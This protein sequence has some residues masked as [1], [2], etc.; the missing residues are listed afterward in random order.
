MSPGL[1][2]RARDKEPAIWSIA[3]DASVFDA[4]RLMAEKDVGLLL[5][6]DDPNGLPVGVISE[7]DYARRVI[8][9]GRQSK[10]AFVADI[11]TRDVTFGRSDETVRDGMSLMTEG[12]FR[13]L[14]IVED[15]R[16]IG[17]VSLGGLAKAVLADRES[18]SE[19]LDT[20]LA[21]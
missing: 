15:G 13:H 20:C 2:D 4:I 16:V 21:G 9:R 10:A 18:L 8:L 6:M 7:R 1:K 11:M 17:V 14:P 5:V 19:R 3:P 12:H